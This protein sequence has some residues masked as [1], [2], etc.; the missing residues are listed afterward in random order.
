MYIIFRDLGLDSF[1]SLLLVEDE[2]Q[3]LM[4]YFCLFHE[5]FQMVLDN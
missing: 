4:L 5:E 3:T 2:S 1:I